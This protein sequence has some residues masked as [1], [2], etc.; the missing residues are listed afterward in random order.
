MKVKFD[1]KLVDS[2][3]IEDYAILDI[4]SNDERVQIT[5]GMSV[6]IP[7]LNPWNYTDDDQMM[8]EIIDMFQ[9]IGSQSYVSPLVG[10]QLAH[11]KPCDVVQAKTAPMRPVVGGLNHLLVD[12]E[13]GD[14]V[15]VDPGKG[16]VSAVMEAGLSTFVA[17]YSHSDVSKTEVH[18]LLQY[19]YRDG[20]NV[21][22]LADG[23]P[24]TSCPMG[25]I[26]VQ[27]PYHVDLLRERGDYMVG[28]ATVYLGSNG[29]LVNRFTNARGYEANPYHFSAHRYIENTE[30]VG[31]GEVIYNLRSGGALKRFQL[32]PDGMFRYLPQQ[33]Y[34]YHRLVKASVKS[35]QA[36]FVDLSRPLLS[37][38]RAP[39]PP[40]RVMTTDVRF[41]VVVGTFNNMG[42]DFGELCQTDHMVTDVPGYDLYYSRYRRV[43]EEAALQN[44]KY[45]KLCISYAHAIEERRVQGGDI[46]LVSSVHVD[47]VRV[48]TGDGTHYL[49]WMREPPRGAYTRRI[50]CMYSVISE[51]SSMMTNEGSVTGV[52]CVS[53]VAGTQY[54]LHRKKIPVWPFHPG[55]HGDDPFVDPVRFYTCTVPDD[56]DPSHKPA[57]FYYERGGECDVNCLR[58]HVNANGD[59]REYCFEKHAI[60]P[61]YCM[62]ALYQ[63]VAFDQ[64]SNIP[65]ADEFVSDYYEN[66]VPL[67]PIGFEEGG[68]DD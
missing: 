21:D 12:S 15:A 7:D 48:Y 50:G 3:L 40:M 62:D 34:R 37:G 45:P 59:F 14:L 64:F 67:L 43:R 39:P 65:W 68:E 1:S 44:K 28:D 11:F 52:R 54:E 13:V 58:S 31:R 25:P 33:L 36:F 23:Q 4:K 30:E 46:W 29:H 66:E 38:M 56:P 6:S 5:T 26:T 53:V 10:A 61:V 55:K 20:V 16:I 18:D 51:E 60:N 41:M 2:S 9:L 47:P 57:K 27:V 17:A 8:D 35:M 19:A 32:F 63:P 42:S 24:L 49:Y 22:F